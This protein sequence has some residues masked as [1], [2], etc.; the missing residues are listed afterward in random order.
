[1]LWSHLSNT[2]QIVFNL[3]NAFIILAPLFRRTYVYIIAFKYAMN[4]VTIL[5]LYNDIKTLCLLI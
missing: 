1:M 2:H 5:L 3:E 4:D